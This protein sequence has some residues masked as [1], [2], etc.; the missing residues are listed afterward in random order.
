MSNVREV[1]KDSVD[2]LMIVAYR[3]GKIEGRKEAGKIVKK[4]IADLTEENDYDIHVL[5]KL[6][7]DLEG[8]E[9]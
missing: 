3:V 6:L 7:T 5:K 2:D 4:R 9:E 8:A 1:V